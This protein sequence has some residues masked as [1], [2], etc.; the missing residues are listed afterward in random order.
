MSKI[1]YLYLI[2]VIIYSRYVVKYDYIKT[3][4]GTRTA[5]VVQKAVGF[6]K[7]LQGREQFNRRRQNWDVEKQGQIKRRLKLSDRD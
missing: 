7:F 2:E 6:H 3:V 5:N 1:K 4:I